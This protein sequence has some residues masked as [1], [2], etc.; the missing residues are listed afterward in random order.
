VAVK[1][2][3][4]FEVLLTVGAATAITCVIIGW[5]WIALAR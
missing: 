5:V 3:Q 4:R 2:Y 1:W